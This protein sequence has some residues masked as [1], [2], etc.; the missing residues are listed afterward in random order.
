AR[1]VRWGRDHACGGV[2]VGVDSRC[3]FAVFVLG[4][5]RSG[6]FAR[7]GRVIMSARRKSGR[8]LA[9]WTG[10]RAAIRIDVDVKS[11][12]SDWQ[13]RE[14]R[15][16][17]ESGLCIGQAKGSNLFADAICIDGIHGDDFACSKLLS[18]RTRKHRS[19]HHDMGMGSRLI[20][21]MFAMAKKWTCEKSRW[22]VGRNSKDSRSGPLWRTQS[23][24]NAFLPAPIQ[25]YTYP[26]RS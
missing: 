16:Y 2:A 13:I 1:V 21:A 6:L 10:A 12:I 18:R 25:P 23:T 26:S 14:L 11:V 19:D 8:R 3:W 17:F 7:V 22:Q 24:H 9:I 5:G 4:G 15:C 20:L